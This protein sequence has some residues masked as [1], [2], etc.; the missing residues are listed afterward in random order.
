A[1][2]GSYLVVDRTWKQGDRLE[3]TLPM[4][5]H[6]HPMP[7]DNGLQAVMYGP[8]VLAG[9][10]GTDGITSANRRAVPTAPRTVPDYENANPP[11]APTIRAASDDPSSWIAPVP[12]RPL[13][14]RTVGQEKE[15]TLAPLHTVF[16]ERYVIYWRLSGE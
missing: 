10:L 16:D 15:I 8:L 4:R 6:T 13:E 5:L 3:L 7:D 14:F 1:A 11:A 2:P 12:G 9:K